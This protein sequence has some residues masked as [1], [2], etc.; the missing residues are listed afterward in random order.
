MRLWPLLLVSSLASGEASPVPVLT[1]EESAALVQELYA[2]SAIILEQQA[3]IDKAI[4][5]IERYKTGSGCA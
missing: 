4:K 1:P 5:L 2:R 3:T